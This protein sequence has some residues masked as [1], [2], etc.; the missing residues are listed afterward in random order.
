[1]SI[2]KRITEYFAG[3]PARSPLW[4]AV[5][6]AWLK[7]SSTCA[8]CGSADKLEVH[9][10]EPYH[11]RPDLELVASNFITLCENGGN[12]HLFVGHLKNWKSYNK[13]VKEDAAV[14]LKKIRTRP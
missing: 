14:V 3:M 4:P 12:C 9:H 11:Q 10:I 6:K 13:N 1:M 2:V 7:T 8:A 5:R